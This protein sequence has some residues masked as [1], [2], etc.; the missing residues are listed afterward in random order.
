[1]K[2]LNTLYRFIT[3][4]RSAVLVAFALM[5][6]ITGGVL[7]FGALPIIGLALQKDR[8]R[9]SN[10]GGGL[11]KLKEIASGGSFTSMDDIGYLGESGLNIDPKMLEIVDERGFMINSI[12]SGEE[13]R[14]K[15]TILQVSIDEINLLKQAQNKYYHLYYKSAALP[16]GNIQEIYIPLV[17]IVNVLELSFKND[18]R[19]IQVEFLALMPKAALTVTPSG[20]SVAADSYGTILEGSSAVGEVTTSSG[21][22]YTT[23]V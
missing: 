9:F 19:N 5:L 3:R 23:I 2:A 4:H 8:N 18:K 15:T 10:K 16:N 21:T 6:V 13:W 7:S 22:I 20:L 12:T 17:K 14:F 11:L 1:M